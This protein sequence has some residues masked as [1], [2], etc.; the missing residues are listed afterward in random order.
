MAD[1]IKL[2]FMASGASD[3]QMT[4]NPHIDYWWEH[5]MSEV[6]LDDGSTVQYNKGHKIWFQLTWQQPQFFRKDQYDRLRQIHNLHVGITIFP[7]PDSSPGACYGVL[8]KGNLDFH[9]VAGVTQIGYEGRLLLEGSSPYSTCDDD[10][11]FGTP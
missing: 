5:L 11:V 9:P 4:Y 7:A 8:W 1:E 6:T 3:Y 2:G 10:I